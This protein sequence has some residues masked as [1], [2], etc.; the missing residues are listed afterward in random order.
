M[1]PPSFLDFFFLNFCF[2]PS[3]E[4]S[5]SLEESELEEEEESGYNDEDEEEPRPSFFFLTDDFLL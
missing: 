3:L 4:G 1:A 5:E 2:F